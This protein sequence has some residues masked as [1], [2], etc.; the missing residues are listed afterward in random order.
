MKK[1]LFLSFA[2]IGL[3]NIC[4][5]Q[6][7]RDLLRAN[8]WR[9]DNQMYYLRFDNQY[10]YQSADYKDSGIDLDNQSYKGQ[11]YLSNNK[12]FDQNGVTFQSSLVGTAT[13]GKYIVL[14]GLVLEIVKLTSTEL[15]LQPLNTTGGVLIKYVPYSGAL[16]SDFPQ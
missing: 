12:S 2:L 14:Y 9:S 16:P 5:G 13:T 11:Y 6:T 8:T 4:Y 15:L 10:M 7:T 1:T 3:F